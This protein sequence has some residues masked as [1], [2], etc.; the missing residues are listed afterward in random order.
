MLNSSGGFPTPTAGL[1]SS[2]SDKTPS[3]SPLET[4]SSSQQPSNYSVFFLADEEL[5][6]RS[7]Q[8]ASYSL[9]RPS[10]SSED[11]LSPVFQTEHVSSRMNTSQRV[12]S[13]SSLSS[14]S[15]T[16]SQ[17]Y[18]PAIVRTAPLYIS[19]YSSTPPIPLVKSTISSSV[20]P[21]NDN[22]DELLFKRRSPSPQP[23]SILK[24]PEQSNN[25]MKHIITSS[26]QH[27]P[28]EKLQQ[29]QPTSFY[30]HHHSS[31]TSSKEQQKR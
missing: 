8:S 16:S 3:F 21:A 27:P 31:A 15:T 25:L 22:D 18:S 14:S 20:P 12:P 11:P 4:A 5:S 6:S 1:S 10:S 17:Q 23:P 30:R 13:N 2:S 29:Q 9:D 19:V 24:K 28:N 26:M 7:S